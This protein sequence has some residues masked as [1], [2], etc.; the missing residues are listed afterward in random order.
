[1]LFQTEERLGSW[2][3]RGTRDT[4]RELRAAIW[5]QLDDLI[6]DALLMVL[7]VLL[8]LKFGI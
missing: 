8:A 2:S 3:S 1:M 4:A 7:W 6:F 5:I